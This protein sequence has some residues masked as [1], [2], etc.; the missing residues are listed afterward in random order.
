MRRRSSD[1]P[2]KCALKPEKIRRTRRPSRHLQSAGRRLHE[3][4]RRDHDTR[5]QRRAS[6]RLRR[7]ISRR[8]V[9]P[10]HRDRLPHLRAPHSAARSE[11][12]A[13]RGSSRSTAR[14]PARRP[15]CVRGMGASIT[16]S[17]AKRP[18][19]STAAGER[20]ERPRDTRAR[21]PARPRRPRDVFAAHLAPRE[22]RLFGD[23][24]RPPR[25]REQQ[26]RGGRPRGRRRSRARSKFSFRAPRDEAMAE[27][28]A[29]ASSER[30]QRPSLR[31]TAPRARR[32][33]KPARTLATASC[34]V[35]RR[36]SR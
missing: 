22:R 26:G 9:Q 2:V 14:A 35:S 10:P 19:R 18:T 3:P 23:R 30:V 17:P 15:P 25:A 13:R 20:F 16:V 29:R 6:V 12:S 28:R 7:E 4:S 36:C 31:A 32:A 8:P 27:R 24:D 1:A 34:R 33:P 21:E 11:Q 5:M